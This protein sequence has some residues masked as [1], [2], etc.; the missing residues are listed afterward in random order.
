M[1]FLISLLHNKN[2]EIQTPLAYEATNKASNHA[3]PPSTAWYKQQLCD[4]GKQPATEQVTAVGQKWAAISHQLAARSCQLLWGRLKCH[5][6][7]LSQAAPLVA[8]SYFVA[9]SLTRLLLIAV[10]A[11]TVYIVLFVFVCCFL[12]LSHFKLGLPYFS[13]IT[14]CDSLCVSKLFCCYYCCCYFGFT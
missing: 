11:A 8:F 4:S 2:D 1:T 9:F 13:F 14:C 5:T 3:T 12:L 10:V 6:R 7:A